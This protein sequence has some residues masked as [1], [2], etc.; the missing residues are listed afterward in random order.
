MEKKRRVERTTLKN[1]QLRFI[2]DMSNEET[3]AFFYRNSFPK[4]LLYVLDC[5]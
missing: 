3:V 5:F 4:W 1:N 2:P